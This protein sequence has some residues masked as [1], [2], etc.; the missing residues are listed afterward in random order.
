MQ[1]EVALTNSCSLIQREKKVLI[2]SKSMKSAT[3]GSTYISLQ[4]DLKKKTM[5]DRSRSKKVQPEV[6]LTY[7]CKWIWKGK[8]CQTDLDAKKSATWSSTYKLM[9]VWQNQFSTKV[10]STIASVINIERKSATW[11]SIYLFLQF[12]LTGIK[13]KVNT[14]CIKVQ[15]EVALT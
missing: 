3:W 7:S 5:S 13:V 4:M 2:T 1:P 14:K 11:G 15:P 12:N 8:A 9:K 6:A 10:T